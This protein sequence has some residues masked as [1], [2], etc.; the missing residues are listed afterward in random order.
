MSEHPVSKLLAMSRAAQ[1][2]AH[3]P[4]STKDVSAVALAVSMRTA[5]IT[6]EAKRRTERSKCPR[7]DQH[8]TVGLLAKH[9]APH[10]GAMISRR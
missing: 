6:N 2:T 3:D 9:P 8:V 4:E 1:S 5:Q 10:P 7:S